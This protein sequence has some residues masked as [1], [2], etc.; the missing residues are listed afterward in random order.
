MTAP[1]DPFRKAVEAELVVERTGWAAERVARVM[2]RLERGV[3][4]AERFEALVV[5]LADHNAFTTAG[6]TLYISRRLLE[7]LADDD[8]AA[9]VLAHELA[10]HRLGHV[11][12]LPRGL[13][14]AARV[15]GAWLQQRWIKAPGREHDAD[16]LAIELCLAA[17]YDAERCLAA[18]EHLEQVHLDYGDVDGVLGRE[19]G[20]ARSHPALRSRVARVRAHV[21][22][23]GRSALLTVDRGR[24]RER[25]RRRTFALT[26]AGSAVMA[27]GLFVVFR[28]G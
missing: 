1:D 4:P 5:W 16:L 17:G 26:V 27:L 18:L 9:F 6:R 3:A 23:L 14:G 24:A 28:R 20:R 21:G 2:A 11:P 10:H 13:F 7:R 15:L 22:A 25:R 8:A 12:A 19:D